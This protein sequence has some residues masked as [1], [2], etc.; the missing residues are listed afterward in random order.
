MKKKVETI[1]GLIVRQ[2]RL[3][4]I[5]AGGATFSLALFLSIGWSVWFDE[6]YSIMLAQRPIHE[7]ISLTAVDAHPPVYYLFLKV[8]ASVLGWSEL[9]LRASSAIT[10][11]VAVFFLLLVIRKLFSTKV[12]LVSIFFVVIAPFMLR[13]DYEIRMYALVTCICMIATWVMLRAVESHNYRWWIVYATLV[14]LGMYT[15]YMSVVIWLAHVVWLL[16]NSWR[17]Q[18]MTKKKLSIKEFVRRPY[19]AAYGAA[20]F[21]FLPW[22]PTVI[23]QL[24]SSALPPYMSAMTATALMN[25]VSMSIGYTIIWQIGA[26]ISVG[27][28]TIL[29]L[30]AL[31]FKDVWRVA[32]ARYRSGIV[33]LLL[34]FI[35]SILFYT[36]ISL[37]PNPPR[38]MERYMVH[39]ILF[40]YASLGII[41]A[42]GWRIGKTVKAGVLGLLC[43]AMLIGGVVKLDQVGNYNFQ[44]V[45][46]VQ[47]KEVRA[48]IGCEQTTFITADPYGYIDMWYDMQGCNLRSFQPSPVVYKGGYAPMNGS[49][50]LVSSTDDI[51]SR[52]IAFVYFDD[53]VDVLI[54]DSRYQK[55]GERSIDATHITLYERR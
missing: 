28:V 14:T 17:A 6:G 8:W 11:A 29:V 2:W 53:S 38:F 12:A 32:S 46:K 18:Q 1:S 9:S 15:L 43:I 21:A 4:F 48:Q 52:R 23:S 20:V 7:L 27:L 41:V 33:L 50:Q 45:Q 36:I 3:F 22:L 10:G 16:W 37:P 30:Y 5:L 13:Y 24:T 39:S 44:R 51:D 47:A 26:W 54:P 34:G 25:I 31:L 19:V 40:F 42:L 49:S 55:I 35:V